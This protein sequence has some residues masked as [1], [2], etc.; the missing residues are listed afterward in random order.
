MCTRNLSTKFD[1]L[2]LNSEKIFDL[3]VDAKNPKESKEMLRLKIDCLF[4]QEYCYVLNKYQSVF[5][6]ISNFG[7][8]KNYRMIYKS[9][10]V[11]TNSIN[12]AELYIVKS[13]IYDSEND[14]IKIDFYDLNSKIFAS[15]IIKK[16][17]IDLFDTSN[18][19]IGNANM[20]YQIEN[21]K[22]FV[23]YLS[24]GL[25]INLIIGVDFTASNGSPKDCN[26]LHYCSSPEP[27]FYERAIISCGSILSYYD[28][29][30][31]FPVFGFGAQFLGSNIVNH[32]FNI[33]FTDNPNIIGVD[34]IIDVYKNCVHNLN[35]SGPTYFTPL[36][37]NVLDVIKFNQTNSD[38]KRYYLLMILTDGQINDMNQTCDALVEASYYP[39]SIIIIGIGQANFDNMIVLGMINLKNIYK[40]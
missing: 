3:L 32:C 22:S 25:Q 33:N 36:I 13:L 6:V 31:I 20:R 27:N 19:Y 23:D 37:R 11:S 40:I 34:K 35:F 16:R 17:S 15:T 8:G 12:F 5:Y 9:E 2:S 24:D 14:P 28:Y 7:D 39:I 30:K 21:S 1:V 29:D 38:D 26:S 10:E 18:K 4:S